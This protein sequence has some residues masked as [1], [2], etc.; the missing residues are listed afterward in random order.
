MC[1]LDVSEYYELWNS[2]SEVIDKAKNAEDR[3]YQG[4]SL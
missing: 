4:W 1:T 3:M 2:E